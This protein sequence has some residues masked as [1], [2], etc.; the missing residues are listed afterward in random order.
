[1]CSMTHCGQGSRVVGIGAH[2]W[3]A[4]GGVDR[5]LTCSSVSPYRFP[6]G[7]AQNAAV[8]AAGSGLPAS[9]VAA[10]APDR[11]FFKIVVDC[12][13]RFVYRVH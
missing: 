1:M 9:G 6:R 12:I 3:L 10:L 5:A 2:A 13:N 4:T 11:F 7:R 8:R